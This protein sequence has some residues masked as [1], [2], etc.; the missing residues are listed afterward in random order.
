M[1]RIE[2][3]PLALDLNVA[4]IFNFTVK[5]NYGQTICHPTKGKIQ[6]NFMVK[7]DECKNCYTNFEYCYYLSE[8]VKS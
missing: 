3:N 4:K 5:M 8:V 6:T 7:L 2:P 1:N